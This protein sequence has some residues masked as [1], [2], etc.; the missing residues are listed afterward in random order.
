MDTFSEALL[1]SESGRIPEEYDWFAP[2]V[3]DWDCDYYDE[4]NN[5][6]RAPR[7]GLSFLLSTEGRLSALNSGG[8]WAPIP[9]T[10][11]RYTSW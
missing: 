6:K 1:S 7:W 5:Q 10:C 11:G 9:E 2:L 4:L 8:Y 3:G